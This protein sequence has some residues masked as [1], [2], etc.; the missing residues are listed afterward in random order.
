MTIFY[1]RLKCWWH[2]RKDGKRDYPSAD[3][4][5]RPEFEGE[6]HGACGHNLAGLAMRWHE[7][8]KDAEAKSQN[9]ELKA[10]KSAGGTREGQKG[11]CLV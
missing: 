3:D 2:G 4:A 11:F 5:S 7:A 6:I 10:E 9:L 1:T 8:E